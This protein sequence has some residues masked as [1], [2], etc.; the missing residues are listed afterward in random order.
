MDEFYR[1]DSTMPNNKADEWG[2]FVQVPNRKKDNPNNNSSTADDPPRAI[3]GGRYGCAQF[4][5]TCGPESLQALSIGR[6]TLF[7]QEAINKGMLKYERT[8]LVKN[9]PNEGLL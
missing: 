9:N 3:P 5:K 8:L 1:E 4:L 2:N 6:L 7:V